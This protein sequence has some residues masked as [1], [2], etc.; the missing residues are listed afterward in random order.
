MDGIGRIAN[1]RIAIQHFEY[2]LNTCSSRLD[3]RPA[4][5][6]LVERRVELNEI[7][8]EDHQL[9]EGHS[10]RAEVVNQ[11]I[12]IRQIAAVT[13][14]HRTAQAE[15]AAHKEPIEHLLPM[16]SQ[17]R[18]NEAADVAVKAIIFVGLSPER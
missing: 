6:E 1:H 2:A 5:G 12:A 10:G 15:D 7:R 9:A 8:Q 17:I 16:Q 14:D 3:R 13:K 4:A 18:G 11:L